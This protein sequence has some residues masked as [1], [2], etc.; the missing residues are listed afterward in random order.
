MVL[1]ARGV[2]RGKAQEYLQR[3]AGP[4]VTL[5]EDQWLAIEALVVDRKRAL[6]VQRTGWGKSAVYF[7]ATALLREIGTGPTVIVSPL[8]ALMRNQIAAATR[9]GIRATTINSTNPEEWSNSFAAVRRG[10]VDVLLLSPERLNNP[11]FRDNVMPQ[12][13]A[14]CG[15]LVVDEAHCISDWG[16]DFRPDF[17]RLRKL[18]LELP[19][20]IPVLATTA[21]AN[22]RVVAD[23]AEV[24]GLGRENPEVLVLRG[25]L[26]RESLRLAVVKLPDQ[27]DRLAWLG[28]RLH[29]FRGSGIIYTLTVAGTQEVA[30]YLRGRGHKVRAYSGQTEQAERL[31]AEDELINNQIKALV[32]TSA[33]GMGFDK[34]DLAFVIHFGAPSTPVAYYQQIGRAGRGVDHADA[35]LLPGND[36]QSI[37]RYFASISFPAQAQVTK[38]LEALQ[39]SK[40]SLSLPQL[41][42]VVDLSRSRLE[43]ML[44][45]LDVEGVVKRVKG[46]WES[47][48]MPFEYDGDRFRGV[49]AVRLSE[50]DAMLRFIETTTC[51]MRFLREQLDDP[52]AVDCGRCDNCTGTVISPSVTPEAR[53]TAAHYIGRPGVILEPRRQW[54]NAMTNF[55]IEVRGKIEPELSCEEGRAVARFASLGYGPK[56]RS[57]CESEQIDEVV[58]EEILAASVAVLA[59]WKSQ[60]PTRPLAVVSVGSKTHPLLIDSLANHLSA[61]GHLPYLGSVTHVGSSQLPRSNSAQRLKALWNAYQLTD[62]IASNLAGA[63]SAAPLFLVDDFVDSGWTIAVVTRQLRLAGAG[64]IYPFVLGKRS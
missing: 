43:M 31:V 44:K 39:E 28:D 10:E 13:A 35:I 9:A 50:Q 22:A 63:F 37:W 19:E 7:I 45:I 20:G 16:H 33:L 27:S 54:P 32:A 30:D 61:I 40:T 52:Y 8:L 62:S 38:T 59:Q 1:D 56:I 11:G 51:R 41:E 5:R 2:L 15:L 17:R 21:T 60:W 49:E 46:G 64:L 57:L 34:P 29:E 23:V 3:L 42:T 55:G 48:G 36:D 53:A 12:L 58:P 25:S 26:E 47:T 14:T 6:V 18:L 4:N 24:L